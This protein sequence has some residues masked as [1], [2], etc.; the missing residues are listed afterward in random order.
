MQAATTPSHSGPFR[1][2]HLQVLRSLYDARH[3]T[4]SSS[5]FSGGDE[6]NAMTT[7][8]TTKEDDEVESANHSEKPVSNEIWNL[9]ERFLQLQAQYRPHK[10][11]Q[12]HWSRVHA[13]STSRLDHIVTLTTVSSASIQKDGHLPS[14]TKNSLL[15][16]RTPSYFT[17]G[18]GS[19]ATPSLSLTPVSSNRNNATKLG[20]NED[21]YGELVT[22]IPAW[23][24][25]NH[26]LHRRS[27]QCIQSCTSFRRQKF[28]TTLRDEA[29]LRCTALHKIL[30]CRSTIEQNHEH[31]KREGLTLQHIRVGKRQKLEL[32]TNLKR[33]PLTKTTTASSLGDCIFSTTTGLE[34]ERHVDE[35]EELITCAKIKLHLWSNLLS[36][37]REIVVTE[38]S[39]A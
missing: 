34:V 11:H 16:P 30:K 28:L 26:M 3:R 27:Q 15:T 8:T 33:L 4:T 5:N 19:A 36:S 35:D 25:I 9:M 12:H 29:E 32:D 7:T 38:S 6:D 22:T 31:A 39:K 2:C 1:R 24:I 18:R 14:T 37:V 13:E 21:R 17:S 10:E 23:N 20:L